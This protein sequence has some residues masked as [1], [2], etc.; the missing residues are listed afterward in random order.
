[1]L[2]NLMNPH[3][4]WESTYPMNP[5]GKKGGK[6]DPTYP[7]FQNKL[8]PNT[9]EDGDAPHP[10]TC[11]VWPIHKAYEPN[12]GAASR[13]LSIMPMSLTP[14]LHQEARSYSLL[15]STPWSCIGGTAYTVQRDQSRIC[16]HADTPYPCCISARR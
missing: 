5:K 8:P 1:M 14:E 9:C 10:T 3:A 6:H 11:I 15:R 2:L 4:L 13:G 12:P 16:K 7:I